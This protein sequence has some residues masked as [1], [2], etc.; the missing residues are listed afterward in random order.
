MRALIPW[1]DHRFV[2]FLQSRS[3]HERRLFVITILLVWWLSHR[4]IRSLENNCQR[5][6]K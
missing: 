4:G 3:V 5:M 2:L 6:S 1:K